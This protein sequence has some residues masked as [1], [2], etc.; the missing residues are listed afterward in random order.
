MGVTTGV[1]KHQSFWEFLA[2]ALAFSTWG[3]NFRKAAVALLC[4]NSSAMQSSISLKGKGANLQ[5]ARELAWRQA[6]Y[7]WKFEVGH[8]PK[9]ANLRA[10]ALSRVCALERTAIPAELKQA[11]Q[12]PAYQVREFWKLRD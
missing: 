8:L 6:K 2:A 5:I 7:G 1:P 10:D 9:E 11:T 3:R 12:V 4:D